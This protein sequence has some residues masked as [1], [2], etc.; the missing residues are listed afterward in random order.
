MLHTFTYHNASHI[1][2]RHGS[3]DPAERSGLGSTCRAS[4]HGAM[5]WPEVI[6]MLPRQAS[7]P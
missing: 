7:P 3:L 2:D 6:R 4:M 5:Q 1:D